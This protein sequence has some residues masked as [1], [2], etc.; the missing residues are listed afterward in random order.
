MIEE[1]NAEKK[2]EQATRGSQSL[3]GLVVSAIVLNLEESMN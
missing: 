1:M 2:L 3:F